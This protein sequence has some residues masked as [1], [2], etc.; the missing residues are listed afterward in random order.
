MDR[1]VILIFK[2]VD[3]PSS[4]S[5]HTFGDPFGNNIKLQNIR[6]VFTN[7]RAISYRQRGV[8]VSSQPGT[9]NKTALGWYGY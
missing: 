4:L 7:Q 5:P 8:E 2:V 3:H 6:L 9:K 1:W